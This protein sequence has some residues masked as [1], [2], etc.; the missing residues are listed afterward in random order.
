[1]SKLSVLGN[2][3]LNV[4]LMVLPPQIAA[5]IA[6]A[7]EVITAPSS[8]PQKKEVAVA[9]VLA[10]EG[11]AALNTLAGGALADNPKFKTIVEKMND[12]IYQAAKE[13]AELTDATDGTTGD[14]QPAV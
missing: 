2:T 3:L 4:A 7:K 14:S 13:I 8:G 5:G 9:K 12:A 10:S 6:H 1:M 11:V